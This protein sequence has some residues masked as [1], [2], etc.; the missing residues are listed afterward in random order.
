MQNCSS[1]KSTLNIIGG[2]WRPLIIYTLHG[3]TLRFSQLQKQISGISQK[4]LTQELKKLEN[5]EVIKRVIYPEIPPRVEYSLTDK[6][7]S[8]LPILQ[9]MHEWSQVYNPTN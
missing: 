5:D 4:M 6:G 1:V 8:I 2:K 9:K 3:N 7:T